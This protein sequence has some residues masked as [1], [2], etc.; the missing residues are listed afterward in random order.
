STTVSQEKISY[1]KTQHIEKCDPNHTDKI[2]IQH[3]EIQDNEI[4]ELKPYPIP[5][6]YQSAKYINMSAEQILQQLT[7]TEISITDSIDDL[8]YAL[9]SQHANFYKKHISEAC[10]NNSTPF[11]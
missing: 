9:Y 2:I 11:N 5:K 4:P 1:D 8:I 7:N 3:I 6:S 10:S